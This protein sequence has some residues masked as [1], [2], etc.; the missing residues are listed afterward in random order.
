MPTEHNRRKIAFKEETN[1]KLDYLIEQKQK[2]SATKVY[3]CEV[4]EDLINN[5]YEID[6]IFKP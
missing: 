5:A 3:P 1:Q 6:K 2:K 4:L